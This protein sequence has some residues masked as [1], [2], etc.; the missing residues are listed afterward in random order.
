MPAAPTLD[1]ATIAAE[2]IEAKFLSLVQAFDS[3]TGAQKWA[4][5]SRLIALLS[6][7]AFLI[8]QLV[9]RKKFGLNWFSL[10]HSLAV[11]GMSF[12]AVWL[13]IFAAE[14]LTG[15]TEPLGA[16]LCQGP[17]TTFHSIV[18]AITMGYGLFDLVEAL[19]LAKTDFVLHGIATSSVMSYFC[20]YGV[21]E[22][23]TPMLLM[24]ISTFNLVL[25]A[26]PEYMSQMMTLANI[27]I[28]TLTFT[29]FRMIVCPY[30]WW[31]IFITTWEN[32]NNP[33]SQACLPWHFPYVVFM[34]GMFFNCLNTFWFYKI[35]KKVARKVSGSENWKAKN[36]VKDS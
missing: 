20:E 4:K 33:F 9:T 22:I 21:P 6:A 11:G 31:E 10:S 27:A 35:I 5:S 26:L 1:T 2:S 19:H 32:R 13:N 34:F 24:E 30:L 36:H 12:V 8:I 23:I 29:I 14:S 3:L 18:P 16:I 17:L 7:L 25:M 28:F 15:T